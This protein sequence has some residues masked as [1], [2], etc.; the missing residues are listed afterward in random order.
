MTIEDD[1][2]LIE[3]L[4]EKL[5]LAQ[6]SLKRALSLFVQRGERGPLFGIKN[7]ELKRMA[8]KNALAAVNAILE[9]ETKLNEAIENAR[10]PDKLRRSTDS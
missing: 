4:R 3:N 7:D 10:R 2:V 9:N 1:E 6:K 8:T 5:T